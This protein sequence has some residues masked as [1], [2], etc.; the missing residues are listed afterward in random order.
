MT[1][2][3]TLSCDPLTLRHRYDKLTLRTLLSY[4]KLTLRTL[5][6]DKLTHTEL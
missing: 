2:S 3:H 4:D 5:S 1:N 6:F